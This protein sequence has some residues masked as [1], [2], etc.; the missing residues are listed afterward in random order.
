MAEIT[1]ISKGYKLKI[2]S[3]IEINYFRSAY[4]V[5]LT[6]INDVNVLIGGN[7]SGKSNILKALNLFFN[8][9]TEL[10]TQFF[11]NDDLSRIRE[12]E[13]KDTKGKASIWIKITFNNF[14]KWKSLPQ[15]F[16][17]KRSWNRYENKQTDSYSN[18]LP[19]TTI[20]KF[21]TKLSF[22]YIPAV[23]GRD[24]FAHYLSE[25]HD[26]LIDDEKA[27]VRTS[28]NNLLAAI[29]QSTIDMSEKI[30][31]GLDLE[32]SI[33][34]PEDLR[35]LFSTLDF[36][37]K[38]S[39]YDMPLQ[40]RGDGIQARHIPFILDF[41]ARHSKK[42]HI[43]AYEEPENSLEMSKAFQLATQFEADFSKE[44]QIFLTTHSPA[45]YDLSGPTVKKWHIKSLE[46]NG[47]N[48]TT[49]SEIDDGAIADETLGIA[50]L[51]ANRAKEL[52]VKI[53]DFKRSEQELTTQL[54]NATLHQILVEG[55]SDK[56]ILNTAFNKLFPENE[57]FCEFI[58]VGGAS[59]VSH[60]LK[61]YKVQEKNYPFCI[62][63]LY[64]ND[65]TGRQ[66]FTG[67]KSNRKVIGGFK[68]LTNNK[69]FCGVLIQPD[70]FTQVNNTLMANGI[71]NPELPL[72]IE[73]MFP[74]EIISQAISEG[75]LETSPQTQSIKSQL[76]LFEQNISVQMAE[77]LPNDYQYLAYKINDRSKTNFAEWVKAL[78]AENFESFRT[79]FVTIRNLCGI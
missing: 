79:L 76:G 64:D 31:T 53:E 69:L 71:I 68:E 1:L 47:E 43:W 4:V 34:V 48:K 50:G 72:S 5:D 25:L 36:S 49:A 22:H 30:K 39:G 6:K 52:Y 9:H 17:I 19:A 55:P 38:F 29:N 26:A 62:I 37:T 21:L 61:A 42:Y 41:I 13:V 57:R 24:I 58:S 7:D 65:A 77:K 45:F 70:F 18:N 51:I 75:I 59:N 56:E 23:R 12:K 78:D 14:L 8:N 67:V 2:I 11:F 3:K 33:Q 63:G 10:N 40:K 66:E 20:G 44:N 16:S 32:S 54:A 74:K 27:G 46:S 15:Q 73:Y 28:A 35:Q 60:N